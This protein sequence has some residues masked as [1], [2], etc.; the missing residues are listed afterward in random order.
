[1]SIG[2]DAPPP[3]VPSG[4]LVERHPVLQKPKLRPSWRTRQWETHGKIRYQDETHEGELEAIVPLELFRPV[5]N[6][7][8]ARGP[9]GGTGVRNKHNALLEEW[10]CC[11]S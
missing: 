10:I 8:K 11:R 2:R 6:R 1:M 9:S 4:E 7:L 5:Q 3:C